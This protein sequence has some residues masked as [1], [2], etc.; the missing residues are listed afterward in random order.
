MDGDAVAQ[1]V[2]NLTI[3]ARDIINEI[4]TWKSRYHARWCALLCAT[5]KD[6]TEQQLLHG[7]IDYEVNENE[8]NR[9]TAILKRLNL[10]IFKDTAT[11]KNRN[12]VRMI[13]TSIITRGNIDLDEIGVVDALEELFA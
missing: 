8:A 7:I 3:A 12:I 2:F 6:Y 11:I 4:P 9:L 1:D 5:G 10:L 13:V